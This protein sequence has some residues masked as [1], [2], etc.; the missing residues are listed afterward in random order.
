MCDIMIL[1]VVLY[2]LKSQ[3][4]KEH[5][6][7]NLCHPKFGTNTAAG[8]EAATRM[9]NTQGRSESPR[10]IV[11]ITDGRSTDPEKTIARVRCSHGMPFTLS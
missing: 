7:K 8:I 10:M 1:Y 4:N 5:S 2:R 3:Q 6:A 11:I 9:I